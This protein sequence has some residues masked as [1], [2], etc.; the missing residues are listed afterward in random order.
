[1]RRLEEAL[2]VDE[3]WIKTISW[4]LGSWAAEGGKD[5]DDSL[6][7]QFNKRAV[8]TDPIEEAWC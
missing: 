6:T 5:E 2:K 8:N 1:L 7:R 4:K 3:A